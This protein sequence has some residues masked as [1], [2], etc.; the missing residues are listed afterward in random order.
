[1]NEEIDISID[2][3]ELPTLSLQS[4]PWKRCMIN[5]QSYDEMNSHESH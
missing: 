5:L 4:S 1:M 3:S 2:T